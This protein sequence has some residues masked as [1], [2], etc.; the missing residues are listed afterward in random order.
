MSAP[1]K[2]T[3]AHRK[4]RKSARARAERKAKLRRARLRATK[5]ER[6]THR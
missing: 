6:S 2:K 5:G 4:R 1:K 3:M